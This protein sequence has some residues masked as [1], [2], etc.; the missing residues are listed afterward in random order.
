MTDETPVFVSDTQRDT[1]NA[2]SRVFKSKNYYKRKREREAN[3]FSRKNYIHE[4]G[5]DTFDIEGDSGSGVPD[6]Y[7]EA[8][9]DYVDGSNTAQQEYY[10]VKSS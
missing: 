7:T 8:L 2:N 5:Q 4:T 1:D 9:R 3:K 10:L 6:G